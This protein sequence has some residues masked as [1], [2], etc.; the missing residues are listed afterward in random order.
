MDSIV[1]PNGMALLAN[2]TKKGPEQKLGLLKKSDGTY[3]RDIKESITILMEAHFKQSVPISVGT[4]LRTTV[5]DV[6]MGS[7]CS[8]GDLENSFITEENVSLAINSF[9]SFKAPGKDN[10]YVL[11]QFIKNKVA[12]KR[13]TTLYRAVLA[14]GYTPNSWAEAKV[15]F[16][17]K[18]GKKDFSL[19][20]SWRPISLL[21]CLLKTVERL[22]LWEMEAK[23][24]KE[25]PL[26]HNQHAFRMG[27]STETALS[28]YF[29]ASF[30]CKST[31]C[32]HLF[33]FNQ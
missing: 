20:R 2:I 31:F 14:L 25:T 23:A 13:L 30:R 29:S 5:H 3:A 12:L 6:Q 32:G 1:D 16:I 8:K 4:V 33:R 28:S 17:P 18:P 19:A 15:I 27:F 7:F 11:K 21:S 9:G 26:S 10:L 24:L 22:C